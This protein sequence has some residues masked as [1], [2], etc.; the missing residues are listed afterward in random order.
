MRAAPFFIYTISLLHFAVIIQILRN[1]WASALVFVRGKRACTLADVDTIGGARIVY[2]A[3]EKIRGF[4]NLQVEVRMLFVLLVVF[5]GLFKH[6]NYIAECGSLLIVFF[7]LESRFQ[8]PDHLFNIAFQCDVHFVCF[9]SSTF[10]SFQST[11]IT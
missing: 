3:I 10:H 6:T 8:I 11:K 9:L 7:L 4:D 1:P 5:E 2:G